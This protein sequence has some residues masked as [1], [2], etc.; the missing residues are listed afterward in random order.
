MKRFISVALAAMLLFTGSG[1]SAKRSEVLVS[2]TNLN[3]GENTISIVSEDTP[4]V[5][6][7]SGDLHPTY[8]SAANAYLNNVQMDSSKLDFSVSGNSLT[9]DFKEGVLKSGTS[10]TLELSGLYDSNGNA[11][12]RKEFRFAAKGD[13]KI[14]ETWKL[15]KGTAD[16]PDLLMFDGRV[17]GTVRGGYSVRNMGFDTKA[18]GVKLVSKKGNSV[19]DTSPIVYASVASGEIKDI[20]TEL[21][22]TD[23]VD[24][25]L[26]V[27]DVD[28]E[29]IKNPLKITTES[30]PESAMLVDDYWGDAWNETISVDY[31]GEEVTY[32]AV[33]PSGWVFDYNKGSGTRP[34]YSNNNYFILK[35]EETNASI[36]ASKKFLSHQ[37]ETVTL[38]FEIGSNVVLNGSEIAVTG[39]NASTL[40]DIAKIEIADG[41]VYAYNGKTR[42]E[43]SEFKSGN[44]NWYPCR[45]EIDMDSKTFNMYYCGELVLE[46]ADFYDEAD[47]LSAFRMKTPEAL[48]GDLRLRYL[49]VHRGF[50]A[51][52]KFINTA[53]TNV[54]EYWNPSGNVHVKEINSSRQNDTDSLIL[55]SGSSSEAG[56]IE[57][58]YGIVEESTQTFFRFNTTG[59]GH[60]GVALKGVND[61][62]VFG[63]DVYGNV[64]Y[65]DGNKIS[66]ESLTAGVW[67]EAKFVFDVETNTIDF[68]LNDRK[69]ASK[70]FAF[71]DSVLGIRFEGEGGQLLDDVIISKTDK[72]TTVINKAQIPADDGIDVH[73]IVY[74]MWREGSHFGWDRIG[75]YSERIPYLGFY[76]SGNVEATNT[77]IKWLV[78]HG[79]DAMIIPFSRATGNN[80]YSVKNTNRF[81]TL[82]DGYLNS[83]YRD[84]IE[85]GILYSGISSNSLKS[86][87]DFKNNIVP[88]WIEHYFKH[89]NY[90]TTQSGQAVLY[91]YTMST[92]YNVMKELALEEKSLDARVQEYVEGGN[93]E[94]K[95]KS[96][97]N[98]DVEAEASAMMKDCFDYLESEVMKITD[99][100]GKTRY[101]GLYTVFVDDTT[102]TSAYKDAAECGGDALFR[103][104]ESKVAGYKNMQLKRYESAKNACK[105]A[106][107]NT[108]VNVD[109]VPTGFMGFQ[110]HPWDG[111]TTGGF[112]SPDEMEE[113]LTT[114]RDDV[115]SGE[116]SPEKIVCLA[117]WDE[118]GEGHFFMP[119]EVYGFGYMDAV[120]NVFGDGSEHTDEKPDA[121]EQRRF[122]WFYQN[123]GTSYKSFEWADSVE[124][125]TRTVIKGWYFNDYRV[126]K[127][128]STYKIVNKGDG[129]DSGWVVYNAASCEIV[130]GA[131]KIVA[132]PSKG[133]PYMDYGYADSNNLY[134]DINTADSKKFSVCM[135]SNV[136]DTIGDYGLIYFSTKYTRET[137]G[138]KFMQ[139]DSSGSCIVDPVRWDVFRNGYQD[140]DLEANSYWSHDSV[141]KKLR[142]WPVYYGGTGNSAEPLTMYIDSIEILG[143]IV[144]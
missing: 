15:N 37:K 104:A 119:S 80:G 120:R 66:E 20:Y 101:S 121:V 42:V 36:S 4:V 105:Q 141:V 23:D 18:Y 71:S 52:D 41:K 16:E 19:V 54:P 100:D 107:E 38:D 113:I 108:D 25:Y 57:N 28:G 24:V 114:I 62:Y 21:K 51:Y 91:M 97:A 85:F 53:G 68:Y 125:A 40:A 116:V 11:M 129:T 7:F 131:L 55:G 128:S 45:T 26:H 81:E 137:L 135:E 142:Y 43:L 103:Y 136:V 63:F 130:D 93:T 31:N 77:Q 64:I 112:V 123:D 96:L 124:D 74:P 118:F 35:D 144:Q 95:A 6:T 12:S 84:M 61:Y 140:G 134:T 102:S 34:A 139:T 126:I 46:N 75:E 82:H 27:I 32:N 92:F 8:N 13:D 2:S 138:Y 48:K 133:A 127:D 49:Y 72:T 99:S 73:M 14:I 67:H 17:E 109:Y 44:S 58:E 78:E 88:F 39:Y 98:E 1:I 70:V 86:V 47:T 87:S 90:A 30:V 9:L 94:S 56:I 111:G 106:A 143:E 83:P 60:F 65:F 5:I 33:M 50:L 59:N 10:Y 110:R 132:D 3:T 79:V 29:D 89:D 122:G 115:N 69:L 117:C 22:V 76:D